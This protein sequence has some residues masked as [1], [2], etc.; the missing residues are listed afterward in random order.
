MSD[1]EKDISEAVESV[2]ERQTCE[3]V[4]AA[5]E[6]YVDVA[7]GGEYEKQRA[8]YKASSKLY[9]DVVNKLAALKQEMNET[10]RIMNDLAGGNIS[11][12][13]FTKHY[14]VVR[15]LTHTLGL[16]AAILLRKASSGVVFLDL[17]NKT[18]E[19]KN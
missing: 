1:I 5:V 17:I 18:P 11:Q 9:E 4:F 13:L 7:G 10:E 12:E 19:L 8:D 14:E 16:E 3:E 6:P 15:D 2:D